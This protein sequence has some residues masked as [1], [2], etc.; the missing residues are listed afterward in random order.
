M[1][2]NEFLNELKA[3]LSGI[4]DDE[5]NII[6]EYFS[7]IISDKI[8]DGQN[9]EQIIS[10]L[11]SPESIAKTVVEDYR[12]DKNNVQ[13]EKSNRHFEKIEKEY[14]PCN[15]NSINVDITN[16]TV[17]L[18]Q[19]DNDNIKIT[20][21][22]NK[23]CPKKIENIDGNITLEN[24]IASRKNFMKQI[25]RNIF[26]WTVH[27]L[28]T[29]IEIPNKCTNL[30]FNIHTGNAKVFIDNITSKSIDIKTSN[31]KIDI[32]NVTCNEVLLHTSNGVISADNTDIKDFNA[33][34]SNGKINLTNV[35]SQ[36]KLYIK[37][38]N[39]AINIKNI[40][41]EDISL[42]TSNGKIDGNIIGDINNYN[43]SSKTSNGNNS[44]KLYNNRNQNADKNLLVHTSNGNI[45][46][47][48]TK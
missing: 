5:Q 6:I 22:T 25:V 11:G 38:S 3:H 2:S 35:K 14:E 39:G 40:S 18:K 41:S 21:F 34:T 44:L 15:I 7:E 1:K 12:E 10:A 29:I 36:N 46:V 27:D 26:I 47:I 19:S 31:G 33:K 17:V 16:S 42:V 43:I 4:P 37:T 20:Y 13:S 23:Y 32:S 45:A 9:E 24:D 30:K 28:K 8:D 48:F